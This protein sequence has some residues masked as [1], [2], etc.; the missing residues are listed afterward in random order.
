MKIL[1]VGDGHSNAGPANVNKRLM[2]NLTEQYRILKARNLLTKTAEL[3]WKM[4][5]SDVLVVSGITRIGMAALK[6]SQLLR[7]KSVY[8]MHGCAEYEAKVNGCEPNSELLIRGEREILKSVDLILPVSV[9]FSDWLK[10]RY[11]EYA[12][13][14]EYLFNG[15]DRLP[16]NKFDD[17]KRENRIVSVG[18][19][20]ATKNN[21]VLSEAVEG[22]GGYAHLIVC[23]KVHFQS[24]IPHRLHT[25]YL[26]LVPQEEFYQELCK[27]KLFVLNSLFEPF[28]LSVIDALNCGC[29]ILVS[30]CA[31]IVDL[32]E[33]HD[34]DIVFDPTDKDEIRAKIQYILK[35]PNNRRIASHLNYDSVSYKKRV[36]ELTSY[37]ERL[38]G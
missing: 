35:N 31:G 19:D 9:K 26:G 1:F 36:E 13:K 10:K 2:D 37:C 6:L 15:I 20:R 33:L 25:Q 21:S 18:A 5:T 8:I 27:S 11:P 3:F 14:M 24:A 22:L 34:S 30:N 32:L 23:G 29:S 4:L 16:K 38:L 7:V 28:S 12:C 17:S